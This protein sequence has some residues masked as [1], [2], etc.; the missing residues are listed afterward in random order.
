MSL[1]ASS[2]TDLSCFQIPGYTLI[3]EN[4]TYSIGGAVAIYIKS[5][6]SYFMRNDFKIDSVKICE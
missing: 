2:Q 5:D 6:Y 1:D 4:R 3:N